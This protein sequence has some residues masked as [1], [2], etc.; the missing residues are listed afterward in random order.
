MEHTGT[1]QRLMYAGIGLVFALLL[2]LYFVYQIRVV[3][4]VFLLT[5][6]FSIIVS[7]PVDYLSRKGLRR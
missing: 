7:G 5:L 2:T 6:L 1:R 3:V 4:L